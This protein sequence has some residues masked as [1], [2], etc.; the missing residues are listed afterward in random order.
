MSNLINMGGNF[1]VPTEVDNKEGVDFYIVQCQTPKFKVVES[2]KCVWG[3]EF[4]V[5]DYV[6][7]GTYYQKWGI[8]NKSFVFLGE[9]MITY[10]DALSSPYV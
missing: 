10:V 5:G 6:I 8:S 7:G 3:C 4:D 1:V 9:S 2:F